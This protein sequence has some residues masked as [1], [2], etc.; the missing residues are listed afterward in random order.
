MSVPQE[1]DVQEGQISDGS[2]NPIISTEL[3]SLASGSLV[4]SSVINSNGAFTNSGSGS[5]FS[6]TAA[7]GNGCP[8]LKLHLHATFST[9][10]TANSVIDG[11]FLGQPDSGTNI[12]SGSA[13]ITP[14][15]AP[16][17]SFPV[18][19]V[20]SIDIEQIVAAPV[21]SYAIKT[22]VRNNGAGTS[23]GAS[24]NFIKAYAITPTLPAL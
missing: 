5:A 13:S 15:R 21:S 6:A 20:S 22:L 8:L 3:N 11:W 10:T 7:N 1:Q 17:F 16:D 9:T 4:L 24:G 19:G 23:L 14:N 2:S 12:E 18:G